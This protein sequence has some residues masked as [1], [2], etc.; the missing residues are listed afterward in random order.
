MNGRNET[1]LLVL[2]VAT[3]CLVAGWL[4]GLYVGI[5]Y[6]PRRIDIVFQKGAAIE[7]AVRQPNKLWLDGRYQRYEIEIDDGAYSYDV[8]VVRRGSQSIVKQGD[9]KQAE[10]RKE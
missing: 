7:G 8:K 5:N 2:G 4:A 3:V 1:A 9:F 10:L 6:F